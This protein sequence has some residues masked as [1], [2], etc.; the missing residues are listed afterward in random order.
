MI[1]VPRFHHERDQFRAAFFSRF[2]AAGAMTDSFA[3][4][5]RLPECGQLV[6]NSCKVV[7][8]LK[9]RG[10]RPLLA[11]DCSILRRIR[12]YANRQDHSSV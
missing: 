9:L 4:G 2:R 8:K 1:L 12:L 7:V 6:P 3:A 11:Q 5:G 10:S